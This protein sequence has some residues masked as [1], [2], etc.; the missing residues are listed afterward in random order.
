[1][2]IAVQRMR[3]LENP[4][5][6]YAWGSKT[7]IADLT[8]RNVPSPQPEAELWMGAHPKAPSKVV[9][10]GHT[11]T[12]RD[13]ISRYPQEILGEKVASRFGNQLPFLFKVL[14]ATEPLSIQAHP[15]Q[16][17]AR[18]GYERENRANIPLDAPR[19]NYRD[20]SHKPEIICASCG[21]AGA[22]VALLHSILYRDHLR[23]D[24]ILG[25]EWISYD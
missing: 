21:C 4:I 9:Y 3:R 6:N 18:T 14:A 20:K 12:L 15:N 8:D 24:R 13:L 17:Q 5:Q 7:A 23:F 11:I 1:M 10:N 19:R 22:S 16:D 25:V 2:T